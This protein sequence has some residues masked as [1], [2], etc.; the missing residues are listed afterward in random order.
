MTDQTVLNEATMLYREP[1]K[2]SDESSIHEIW[3]KKL[4][5]R[6]VDASE[7]PDLLAE[8]WVRNPLDLDQRPHAKP[9]PVASA[10]TA[11]ALRKELEAAKVREKQLNE[12]LIATTEE[13]ARLK[14]DLDALT[15]PAKP[16]LK[17]KS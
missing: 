8:G 17:P 11:D 7:V 15:A 2:D 1:A 14:A 4:E 12:R 13:N 3:G 16:A 5:I 10:D 9:K 6:T